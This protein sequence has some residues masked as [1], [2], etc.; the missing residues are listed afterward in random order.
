MNAK[1]GTSK[2][3]FSCKAG[4]HSSPVVYGDFV[5]F[6]SDDGRLY[7]VN[8]SSG[9]SEWYFA[10]N[11]TIDD[12]LLNYITT[13]IISNPVVYN[14]TAYIGIKGI[15]YA[16]NAKT[17]EQSKLNN[18]EEDILKNSETWLFIIFSLLAIIIVTVLYLY[19]SKKRLK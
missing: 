17:S 5:F 7:A 1:D 11:F 15:I 6:G 3:I 13:P 14:G 18:D 16:L 12:D 10:P 19:L 2:W 9:D 8:K 4:I